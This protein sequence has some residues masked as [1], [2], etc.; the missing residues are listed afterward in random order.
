M[1]KTIKSSIAFSGVGLHSG[2]SARVTILPAGAGH[3]IW[4][5][6]TDILVGDGM[7]AAQW[8]AVEQT[9]LC[10]RIVNR[11]GVAVSTIE[12]IMAALAGC[13]VHNAL[14]EV[15]G[16]EVPILDGSAAAFVRG[17]LATGV[18]ELAAPVQAI[19]LLKPVEV[20][21]G[22]A[23]ARLDPAAVLQINFHI[24]FE[25]AAIG[26]QTK[27]LNMSNGSFVRELANSR[28]FCRKADVEMMRANGLA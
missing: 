8:D 15:D 12:H 18:I 1:Q 28:T 23:W 14:I 16:P 6:R 25:D 19:K 10:T 2:R 21:S 24:D 13:G 7:V 22:A 26:V 5:R 4:F 27:S 3:G 11:A 20:H 17:I 9:P